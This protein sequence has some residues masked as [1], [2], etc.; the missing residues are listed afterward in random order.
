[1]RSRCLANIFA[2]TLFIG[3]LS[4]C[5]TGPPIPTIK[6]VAFDVDTVVVN[7]RKPN[8]AGSFPAVILLH[9]CAGRC[10]GNMTEWSEWFLDRDYA[11]LLIYSFNPRGFGDGICES[12]T[13]NRKTVTMMQ[14]VGDAYA[15]LAWLQQQPN[16]KHYQ[17]VV[18]G[19]SNG[20]NTA[21]STVDADVLDFFE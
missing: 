6:M 14:R 10:G 21:L 16:I 1:M 4:T 11:A 8:G 13:G 15:G 2:L 12:F 18:M 17:V 7:Y 5:V 20:G 3:L 9:G 19:I